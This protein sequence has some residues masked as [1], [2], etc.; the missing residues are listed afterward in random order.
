MNNVKNYV[1]LPSLT[2]KLFIL[3]YI[4]ILDIRKLQGMNDY[5]HF[6]GIELAVTFWFL[7]RAD[8]I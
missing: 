7:L 2:G 6:D 5:T 3:I 4:Y 8:N 1:K